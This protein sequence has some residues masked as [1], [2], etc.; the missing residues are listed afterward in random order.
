MII[1]LLVQ[2]I[3][4]ALFVSLHF[5]IL[6]HF[7]PDFVLNL[8]MCVYAR[9]SFWKP[10]RISFDLSRSL[11]HSRWISESPFLAITLIWLLNMIFSASQCFFFPFRQFLSLSLYKNAKMDWMC[12]TTGKECRQKIFD[13]IDADNFVGK[14]F[15]ALKFG[16]TTETITV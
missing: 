14:W 1:I 5:Y 13:T 4:R 9:T 15:A 2:Y 7:F 6:Y 8:F 12:F 16:L 11:L 3:M 10:I